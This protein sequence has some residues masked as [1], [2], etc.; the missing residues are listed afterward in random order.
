MD[1]GK[2][3]LLFA[4]LCSAVGGEPIGENE[5]ALF[6]EEAVPKMMALAKRHDVAHLLAHGLYKNGFSVEESGEIEMMK[7]VFRYERL[8]YDLETFCR[9]LEAAEVDF[10]PLKGSVI[11][12]YY[13][14]PWM[15]TSCDIDVLVRREDLERAISVLVEKLQYIKKEVGPHDVSLFSPAGN[16]IELHFDLVEEGR[17]NRAAD[18]LASVWENLPT[19]EGYRHWHEMTDEYF[20][21]YHI[22]HM[23]KH[24]YEGG[25]GIRPFLDLWL[26]DRVAS[27]DAGARDA[28]LAEGDLLTFANT[29]RRLCRAWFEGEEADE[30]L[31]Q[32]QDFLLHGGVYGT[33]E[34]RV[35]LHQSE[36][37]GRVGYFFSRVF[38]P[39]S[40]LKSYYPILEKHPWLCP[41]MQV[42][43]WFMIFR[44]DVARMAKGELEA[45]GRMEKSKTEAMQTML[46]EIG[47]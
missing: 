29:V 16:H 12:T 4:L 38:V 10:L 22:A 37:G 21:F 30:L 20:Y 45:N 13:A 7:A 28:L 9:T 2:I 26:L 14:E 1:Q 40:R 6:S 11:R 17:A 46:K 5:R 33:T 32:V 18:I 27:D 35:A 23:A 36:K 47:L 44:P 25:C 43:R 31:F 15:R 8:A 24:F 39:M 3:K 41:V 34:N 42:R 19:K